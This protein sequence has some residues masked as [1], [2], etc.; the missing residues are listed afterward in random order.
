MKRKI[1]QL[2]LKKR[3]QI[4]K[5][6]LDYL[7]QLDD[8]IG[9]L[10]KGMETLEE[11]QLIIEKENFVERAPEPETKQK[12]QKKEVKVVQAAKQT[13][14]N[15][16]VEDIAAYFTDRYNQ[17]RRQLQTRL[18][19]VVSISLLKKMQ[20]EKASFIAIISDKRNTQNNNI[21][22]DLEDPTS[23]IRAV[24]TKKEVREKAQNT[25]LDE[26]IGVTGTM[27][28]GIFFI[29]DI[30]W[31]DIPI[32][33]EAK[34]ISDEVYAVFL[35]DTHIGSKKF[36]E[37]DFRKF[38]K[39]IRSD[40]GEADQREMASKV[41]YVFLAGD[42][43]DGI[44]V[45]PKQKAELQ[46]PD[47]YKQYEIAAEHF[48]EIPDEIELII[49]PGNHDFIRL[50]QPQPQLDPEAAAPLYGLKNATMVPN[51]ATVNIHGFDNGGLNVLMYHGVSIDTM[52]A[53]DPALKEGYKHP[54]KVMQSLLKRRHLSPT[55]ATNLMH[56]EE[57]NLTIN[58][59]PDIFHGGHVH[60]NGA[61]LYRG[62]TIINSG[63]WQAQTDFQKLC[64]HTPTPSQ[65]PLLN[66]R[67]REMTLIN[68]RE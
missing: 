38:L 60:S 34:T 8:P 11:G 18:E 46:E 67:T 20:K 56:T 48:S 29:D 52:I 14:T 39:W 31:P 58:T 28:D 9:A 50:A 43:V 12:S 5:G 7:L 3:L 65:L 47:I 37:Q 35:S 2:V 57:D 53:S 61:M 22:L 17:F 54:E 15:G 36:L 49:S 19:N 26:I 23:Q 66:L 33:N 4:S 27:G 30:I 42:V 55:Y 25:V 64:G 40:L 41:K 16:S 68:F 21:L 13:Q 51:P 44:G 1:L 63:A 62:I 6:A 32:H 59:L 24:A 45:Y 10:K